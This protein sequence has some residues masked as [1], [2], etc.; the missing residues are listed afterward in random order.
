M[1]LK[2]EFSVPDVEVG[3]LAPRSCAVLHEV[4][5]APHK[6]DFKQ[7]VEGNRQIREH[8]INLVHTGRLSILVGMGAMR[9]YSLLTN[10]CMVPT[11]T[12][13]DSPG[14]LNA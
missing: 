9:Y 8:G 5:V 14:F 10:N 11:R 13:L 7:D 6:M 1:F 3:D 12:S 2:S 4:V